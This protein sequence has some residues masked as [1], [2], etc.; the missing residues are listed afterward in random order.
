MFA[1]REQELERQ[2]VSVYVQTALTSEDMEKV[3]AFYWSD[4]GKKFLATQPFILKRSAEVT[5]GWAKTLRADAE[6]QLRNLIQADAK[7]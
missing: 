3:N 2:L 6:A 7:K 5:A 4:L 1:S